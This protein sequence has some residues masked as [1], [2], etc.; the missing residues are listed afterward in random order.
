MIWLQIKMN[1][2]LSKTELHGGFCEVIN[3]DTKWTG[4]IR[5]VNPNLV[6]VVSED[7]K[8]ISCRTY[9]KGLPLETSYYWFTVFRELFV[10]YPA[11]IYVQFVSGVSSK[12]H[13]D[14]ARRMRCAFKGDCR[15][16][17]LSLSSPSWLYCEWALFIDVLYTPE[18]S[19]WGL[20]RQELASLNCE[21]K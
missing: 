18:P 10:A 3:V 2:N 8:S 20:C 7:Q 13:W 1:V 16:S 15:I 14:M 12:V 5:I 17:P 19:N 21:S 11:Y 6:L 4:T 9:Y